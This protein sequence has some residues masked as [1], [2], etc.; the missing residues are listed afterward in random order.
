MDTVSTGGVTAT[1]TLDPAGDPLGEFGSE[2]AGA[3]SA[4]D[5]TAD[6]RLRRRNWMLWVVSI[7]ALAQMPFVTLWLMGR[8]L[9]WLAATGTVH[10]ESSPAGAQVRMDGRA[11]GVT[12][13]SVPL[14]AGNRV[15]E[16][17]YG[18]V[19]RQVP[20]AVAARDVVRQHIEFVTAAPAV[21]ATSG[22]GALSVAT[23]PPRAA[24]VFV[25]GVARGTSPVL[26]SDLIEG[27]HTVAVRFPT[28]TVE[29][30]IRVDAG[31]TASLLATMPPAA[32]AL[33]G[34]VAVDV[35]QPLQI[36]EQG[37][38]V[39]TTEI[40]RL[41]LPAGEHTLDFVNDELGFRAQ[42][43]IRVNPGSTTTIPIELPRAPLAINALP[44][45][46]VWVD[47]EP[48]GD[49]PIGNLSATIGRHEILFRHPELGE[50]RATVTVTLKNTARIGVDL[51]RQN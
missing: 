18:D 3:A 6:P 14:D 8:P 15:L 42:R 48:V 1:A 43:T 37:R 12:P 47:G 22:L 7:V 45:A 33:S 20:I 10:V 38:L 44:W 21:A 50:R 51:R 2:S 17:Q 32:N 27:E 30:R 39:G 23:D 35:R 24:A 4:A 5:K 36:L 19:I 40:S 28:G 29:R 11:L 49:T 34:W 26:V 31:A 16:V 25:D 41:M 46:S 9:P 13:L